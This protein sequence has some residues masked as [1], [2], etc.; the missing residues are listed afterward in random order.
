[1]KLSD[2]IQLVKEDRS[3]GDWLRVNNESGDGGF[4][5]VCVRNVMLCIC[6]N[7]VWVEDKP[8]TRIQISYGSVILT[9]GDLPVLSSE[10]I[11]D[12]EKIWANAQKQLA[13]CKASLGRTTPHP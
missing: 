13:D 1:M 3:P 2:I 9:W 6:V 11:Q 4:T 12:H 10:V 8:F 5:M 7:L